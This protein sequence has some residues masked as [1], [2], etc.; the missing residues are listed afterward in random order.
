MPGTRI[1]ENLPVHTM[2]KAEWQPL[3]DAHAE[4][5]DAWSEGRRTRRG[6]RHPIDDFLWDYYSHRPAHLRRWHPGFGIA[7]E[8]ADEHAQWPHYA[9]DGNTTFADVASLGDRR[10]AFEWMRQLLINTNA[11]PGT[12]SCFGLHEWA[13]VY[14][15]EQR[16]VRHEQ[17][18]L[19][20]SPAEIKDIVDDAQ[21]KCTHYDAFRHYAPQAITLNTITPTRET[22]QDL[23]QP[24]CLHANMDVYKWC[25]K[26]TPFI[27]SELTREAFS[28]ARE[29]RQ[30]DM[31]AAPYDLTEWGLTP[32]RIETADG[33]AEYAR[34]QKEFA[35][36]ASELRTRVIDALDGVLAKASS[37]D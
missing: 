10:A 33:R 32:V 24:G 8:D 12:F 34:R 23:E 16:D 31:E 9:T 36:R 26:L 22:Q 7:L 11:R 5:V 4:Q 25:Y 14:G 1:R 18:P 29:I 28:L 35:D 15:L 6:A 17:A 3:A 20:L 19:R 13:M 2:T 30:L 27:S 37:G 21:L